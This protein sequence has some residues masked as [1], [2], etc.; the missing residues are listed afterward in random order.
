MKSQAGKV[1]QLA[2]GPM[3]ALEPT[4]Q[5]PD[6]HARQ[7]YGQAS[8]GCASRIGHRLY[9]P[10]FVFGEALSEGSPVQV[11]ANYIT[12]K[13]TCNEHSNGRFRLIIMPPRSSG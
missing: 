3:A 6:R 11:L 4:F 12:V 13:L 1:R 9:G 5:H 10:T 2:Q 7:Q 8:G